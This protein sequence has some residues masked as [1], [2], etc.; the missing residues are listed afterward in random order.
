MNAIDITDQRFGRL[1]A[2]KQAPKDAHGRLR[3]HCR[4]DCG[5]ECIVRSSDLRYLKVQSCGCLRAEVTSAQT[6]ARF[7]GKRKRNDP[8]PQ[9]TD[10]AL[11]LAAM[12]PER[13]HAEES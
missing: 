5:N 8:P 9:G 10:A 2:F 7:Q 1:L 6:I 11:D 13:N 4:C 12:W 3:W